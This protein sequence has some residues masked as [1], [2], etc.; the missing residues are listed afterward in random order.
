MKT[1]IPPSIGYQQ[2]GLMAGLFF[3]LIVVAQ[4]IQ[5]NL[6]WPT[7]DWG[8]FTDHATY[9]GK[10]IW[11]LLTQHS[12]TNIENYF[13]SFATRDVRNKMLLAAVGSL[14]IS[15]LFSFILTKTILWEPGGRRKIIKVNGP[16][17]YKNTSLTTGLKLRRLK[18]RQRS[19]IAVHPDVTLSKKEAEGNLFVFGQQGSGKSVVIKTVLE[20]IVNN[21]GVAVIYDEKREYTE[22]FYDPIDTILIAPWDKRSAIWDISKDLR[23]EEDFELIANI[24]VS[25]RAED[26][27]W[28]NGARA[29]LAGILAVSS[30]N[31][32]SNWGWQQVV[33]NLSLDT[34]SLRSALDK[35]YDRASRFVENESK[36]THGFI[37]T[38]MTDVAWLYSLDKAWADTGKRLF[39]IRDW[40]DGKEPKIKK[41]I[42]QAHPELKYVGA[43]LCNAMIG[44]MTKIVTAKPDH[45]AAHTWLVLDEL[46]NLPKND[47]LK[48]WMSIG[49]SKGCR[50]LA[51]TQSISQL[52]K[53][54]GEHDTDTLLNLFS[55]IIAL[56]CGAT[57]GVAEYAAKAFGEAIYERPTYPENQ[58]QAASWQKETWRLVTP[59]DLVNLPQS[60]P[61]GVTGYITSSGWNA[62]YRLQWPYPKLN[63]IAKSHV[64]ADWLLQRSSK[65]TSTPPTTRNGRLKGN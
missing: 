33:E 10:G 27:T 48:E 3:I 62:V 14:S 25:D 51:G 16:I 58:G 6:L 40:L 57:G 46:G 24:L 38:L 35:H 45:G 52:H 64:A 43:P 17:L 63:V 49:R 29:I 8:R 15:S 42:V 7:N 4:V 18:K 32:P 20:Q 5:I 13:N 31:G 47:S 56:R 55:T 2:W 1:Y 60:T 61:Q 59:S 23:F 65:P 9:F 12:W 22:L 19:G 50:T 21:G 44:L 28:S 30:A 37:S 26:T 53:T 54:Y 34:L 11:L 39:S 41:I 36:T